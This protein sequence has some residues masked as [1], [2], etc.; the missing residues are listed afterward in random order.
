[1]QSR[2]ALL[3]VAHGLRGYTSATTPLLAKAGSVRASPASKAPR[4]LSA[5]NYYVQIA[6]KD[7]A[8]QS[9]SQRERM[10]SIAKAWGTISAEEKAKLEDYAKRHATKATKPAAKAKSKATLK[11]AKAAPKTNARRTVS[12]KVKSSRRATAGLAP[13]KP[14]QVTPKARP[15]NKKAKIVKA[16]KVTKKSKVVSGYRVF[17]KEAHS[18][19]EVQGLPFEKQSQYIANLWKN[20]SEEQKKVYSDKAVQLPP[21]G[22]KKI[23]AYTVFMKSMYTQADVQAK[24]FEERLTY[25]A[26]CWKKC[27]AEEKKVYTDKAAALPTK[28][29]R[30]SGSR[31]VNGKLTGRVNPAALRKRANLT[32]PKNVSGYR[33]FTKSMYSQADVQA[34]PFTQRLAY[35]AQCWKNCTEEQKKSFNDKATALSPKQE[36]AKG[37]SSAYV[38]FVKSA[39]GQADVQAKPFAERLAYVA[40]QWKGLSEE[41]RKPFVEQAKLNKN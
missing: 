27:S 25:I 38:L 35:I 33:L 40:K 32:S 21:K 8:Y 14:K 2:I 34:K 39:Y 26:Q 37:K 19:K 9:L 20:L 30:A 41:Q 7:K 31:F 13:R 6:S 22:S 36:K 18:K 12:A 17:V 16:A 29:K 4:A 11:K 10:T 5:Y 15:Q 24:P 1:M 3:L 23:S 28:L